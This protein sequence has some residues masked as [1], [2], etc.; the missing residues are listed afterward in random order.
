[1]TGTQK[2]IVYTVLAVALV[3]GTV[4]AVWMFRGQEPLNL[5][6]NAEEGLRG[7]SSKQ[8][9]QLPDYRREAYR[10]EVRRLVGA[11]PE[12]ERRGLFERYRTD[13]EMRRGLRR[14]RHN[15]MRQ[16]IDEYFKKPAAERRAMVDSMIDR[17]DSMRSGANRP[18]SSTGHGRGGGPGGPMGSGPRLG[19]PGGPHDLS[20]PE[21]QSAFRQRMEYRFQ[22][23]DPQRL[24][25][26]MEFHKHVQQRR[27]ERGLPSR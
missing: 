3:S 22:E 21:R 2:Q 14:L 4:L 16:S 11:L 5:P 27:Q 19:G 7:L 23:G 12:K 20:S 8:F 24:A 10:G 13:D 26:M 18:G 15:P 25:K 1:M 6:A 17:M 9:E